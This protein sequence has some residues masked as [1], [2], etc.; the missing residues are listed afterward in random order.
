[1]KARRIRAEMLSV[2][3]IDQL[4]ENLEKAQDES[5]RS[6]ISSNS[7][8]AKLILQFPSETWQELVEYCQQNELDPARQ[9]TEAVASY[10]TNLLMTCRARL[11]TKENSTLSA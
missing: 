9:I 11:R 3:K 8:E 5:G 6:P 7:D 4:I 2:E 1:M 10:Y